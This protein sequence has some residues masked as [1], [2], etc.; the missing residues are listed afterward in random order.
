MAVIFAD[1]TRFISGQLAELGIETF[2]FRKHLDYLDDTLR[3]N[4]NEFHPVDQTA[5]ALALE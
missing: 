1:K 2:H 3:K 4:M 5:Q